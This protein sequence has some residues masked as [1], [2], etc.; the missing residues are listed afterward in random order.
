MAAKRIED[1]QPNFPGTL[2]LPAPTVPHGARRT[3]G[4]SSLRSQGLPV[5]GPYA[6]QRP[7]AFSHRA[8]GR[9]VK[10]R[11]SDRVERRKYLGG[12]A[13]RGND[14]LDLDTT[15]A[16]HPAGQP[17]EFYNQRM[18]LHGEPAQL[19]GERAFIV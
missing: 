14:V 13:F 8:S 10:P 16:A 5:A 9:G 18:A 19:T 17:S 4:T 11:S 6:H 15:E 12:P 2:K 1:R 7:K 3:G